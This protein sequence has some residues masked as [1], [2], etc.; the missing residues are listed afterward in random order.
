M[1]AENRVRV[2]VVVERRAAPPWHRVLLDTMRSVDGVDVEVVA[3]DAA[4][5]AIA[6]GSFH[7]VVDLAEVDCA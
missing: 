6:A 2:A 3:P 7:V 4:P 1:R 5:A